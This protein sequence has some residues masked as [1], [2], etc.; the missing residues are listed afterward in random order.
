MLDL[1]YIPHDGICRIDCPSNFYPD[2]PSGQR[3]C[4][5]CVGSCKKE[6]P[7]ASIESISSAQRYKGCTHINGPFTLS[8]RN[9]GGRKFNKQHEKKSSIHFRNVLNVLFFLSIFADNVV[10]E[11]ET[12]LSDIEVIEGPLSIVRSYPI[13]S[14]GFFKKLHT[15]K[16]DVTGS[17]K[18]G[19]K[20]LENQNLQALFT[21]NVT[22][23]HG[24]M[25]FHFNPKLCMNIIEEFKDNVTELR[26]VSRLPTDEVAPNSNGDKT[27]CNV[28]ELEVK[29]T[30]VS[31][32]SVVMELRPL[33]YE[34]ERQL[35][36]YLLHYMPA[37]YQNVR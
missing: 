7:P 30:K 12:F 8:I 5:K 25:F 37:P 4:T 31:H 32:N 36:G 21:Q 13:L 15:I 18:Y 29:T 1:P 28:T 3:V 34:D 9:P 2:G 11:L 35:L 33:P 20:V 23:E 6:C 17:K 19:L 26:N 22:V 14:L 27:A 24:R 16:G 10:R